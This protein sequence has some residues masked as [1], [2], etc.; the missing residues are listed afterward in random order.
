MSSLDD[1]TDP[2]VVAQ[3]KRLQDLANQRD[4]PGNFVVGPDRGQAGQALDPRLDPTGRSFVGSGGKS[5]EERAAAAPPPVTAPPTPSTG[6]TQAGLQGQWSDFLSRP[7]HRAGLMQFAVN[8]LAG[9]GLG[10]S[11]GSAAE[12]TGR[13]VAAQEEEQKYEEGMAL[14]EQEAARKERETD[15][16]G[17]QA[18]KRGGQDAYFDRLAAQED[19][20]N[21]MAGLKGFNEWVGNPVNEASGIMSDIKA[22]YPKVKSMGDLTR[23]GNEEALA[24]AR[25]RWAATSGYAGS[26][27]A[28]GPASGAQ[29]APPKPAH[30]PNAQLMDVNGVPVWYDPKT[31]R[32]VQ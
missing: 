30:V 5:A 21:R 29:T 15:Y 22:K 32:P 3:R 13:N 17:I 20:Q 10:E 7:E 23:E 11:I 8:M 2:A 24:Y 16:Y 1:N 28:R 18:R 14:K 4:T 27:G 12:A 25:Q 26:V 19:K 9:R 31:K 6:G